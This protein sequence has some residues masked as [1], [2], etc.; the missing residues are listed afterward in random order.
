QLFGIENTVK[1]RTAEFTWLQNQSFMA[2]LASNEQATRQSVSAD[3]ELGK[4]AGKAWDE[5]A[6]AE[7][8]YS[9]FF[10]RQ[11]FSSFRGTR[12]MAIAGQI[13][14]YV[15]ETKKPNDERF[16][17]YRDSALDSLKFGLLSPA[18]IYRDL[19][20]TTFADAL[21]ETVEILGKD[22]PFVK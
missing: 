13:V 1:A 19:E 20:E 16:P 14:R 12:F 5:I 9:T 22:D 3:P 6:N 15:V 7:K 18:P 2:G 21:Q 11:Q 8:L 17:E 4:I 10:K